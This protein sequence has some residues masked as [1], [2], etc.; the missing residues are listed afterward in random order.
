MSRQRHHHGRHSGRLLSS[1]PLS[2]SL[3]TRSEEFWPTE[4]AA[5]RRVFEG[6]NFI[7]CGP[8][9]VLEASRTM[10]VHSSTPRRSACS[11]RPRQFARVAKCGACDI[12]AA[13]P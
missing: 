10:R 13:G 12:R 11:S 7:N 9:R 2:G 8:L 6:H 1:A 3:P 4:R 5:L